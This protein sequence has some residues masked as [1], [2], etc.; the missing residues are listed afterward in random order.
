MIILQ[1][2]IGRGCWYV[3]YTT[4]KATLIQA[5]QMAIILPEH[6]NKQTCRTLMESFTS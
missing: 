4:H 1:S 6:Y 3:I 2:M 5:I